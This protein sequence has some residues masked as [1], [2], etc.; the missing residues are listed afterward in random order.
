[1]IKMQ[2]AFFANVSHELK[3]PLNLI[4]SA[5]QLME[6]YFKGNMIEN[7]E[8]KLSNDINI[9][10][11]NCFRLTKLINNIVDLSKIEGGFL[12]LNL[13]NENIVRITEDIIQSVSD[14]VKCKGINIIFDTNTEE[15][16]IDCDPDNIE[17]ILLNVISNA[18][19]FTNKN[20]NIYVNFYDKGDTVEIAVKDTGIGIEKKDQIKIFER[21][22]QVDKSLSRNVEGTGIG[23]SLVKSIVEMHGGKISVES[24]PGEGSI[25]KI[26]LP[27]RTVE[28]KKI[29]KQTKSMD[30]KIEIINVEFSDIY[31]FS[32][33]KT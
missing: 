13:S 12:N 27:V 20:G 19:K 2:E 23:L 10:K 24:T 26:E 9:I 6:L 3:T 11:Q 33:F 29:T 28:N 8:E 4:F 30:N 17:R 5:N 22:Q 21:F 15:K 7:N 16:L 25:F 1:M 31:H 32:K 14:Y 18:I